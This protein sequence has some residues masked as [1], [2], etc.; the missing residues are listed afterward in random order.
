MYIIVTSKPQEYSAELGSGV[1][2]VETYDYFFYGQ[3]RATHII[4]E[5]VADDARVRIIDA[6]DP[7]CINSVPTKFFGDFDDVEAAREE[8][9]ELIRFGDIDTRLER[10]G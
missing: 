4:G 10:V 8:L 2:A 7:D 1:R 5:V 3:H 6:E 9:E